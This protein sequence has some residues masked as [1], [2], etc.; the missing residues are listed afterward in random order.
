[1]FGNRTKTGP[2]RTEQKYSVR[3]GLFV[4][5]HTLTSVHVIALRSIILSE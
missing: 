1:M 5:A 2:L 3:S 4:G